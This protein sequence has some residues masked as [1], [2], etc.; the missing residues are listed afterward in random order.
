MAP[1]YHCD[2]SPEDFF[3]IYNNNQFGNGQFF[4]A[5]VRRQR[6]RG[7]AA[8][9]GTLGRWLLPF[10][11]NTVVPVAKSVLQNVV[12]PSAKT[13]AK[14]VWNDVSIGKD[15]TTSVKDNGWA[16]LRDMQKR[17]LDSNTWGAISKSRRGFAQSGSGRGRVRRSK[18]TRANKA[19]KAKKGSKGKKPKKNKKPK[20][21]S[22]VKKSKKNKKSK[23][24]KQAKKKKTRAVR[25]RKSV[26]R[27]RDFTYDVRGYRSAFD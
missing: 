16:G 7:L 10:L 27:R 2:L 18:K 24:P 4:A 1:R 3:Q 17:A 13:A 12:V 14:N 23:K 26:K 22:K 5:S 6:G 20:K 21:H 11:R 15:F 25:A 19:K 9:F 8:L